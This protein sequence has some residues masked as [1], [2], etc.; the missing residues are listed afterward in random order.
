[1]PLTRFEKLAPDKRQR[2]LQAAAQ[3]FAAEGFEK[4]SLGKIA[5]GAGVSKPSLY[6]Y[7]EDKADLY[8][9]VVREAWERLSPEKQLDVGSLSRDSFWP[10]LEALVGQNVAMCRDEP[11]L[12]AV[13]KLAYHP[14]KE[15]APA[16]A[17]AAIFEEA[18]AFQQGLLRRGQALGTVRNDLPEELLISMLTAADAAADHWMVDHWEQ[19]G[20][21]EAERI[22]RVVFGAIRALVSPPLAED[23]P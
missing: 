2:L 5:E 14:P 17:V 8:V 19:L 15:G 10:A 21:E 3:E 9:T 13:G 1:M 12:T 7:F 4:A 6:Y 20:P 11:W 18:R 16:G 22:S 23:A